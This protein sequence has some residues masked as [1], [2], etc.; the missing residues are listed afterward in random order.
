[1][2]LLQVR[3]YCWPLWKIH[4]AMLG[5][6]GLGDR[7]GIWPVRMPNSSENKKNP[8]SSKPKLCVCYMNEYE[9]TIDQ[10]LAGAATAE[11]LCHSPNGSTFLHE[12]T[13]WPPSWNYNVKSKIWLCAL[14]VDPYLLEQQYCQISS[15][16]NLKWRSL[17]LFWRVHPT[18]I[19][20]WVAICDQFLI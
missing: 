6:C 12:M 5:H 10:E 2:L 8:Q 19:T 20:R 18:R 11:P 15:R 1:M 17:R 16:S 4:S 9:C 3:Y 13:S 14:S 7:N